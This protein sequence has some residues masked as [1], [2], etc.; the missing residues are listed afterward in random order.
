MKKSLLL[1]LAFVGIITFS[2]CSKEV[3][4]QVNDPIDASPITASE[5]M[6]EKTEIE[7]EVKNLDSYESSDELMAEIDEA[8]AELDSL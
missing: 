5:S 3:D 4:T 7:V 6:I 1:S 8:L 2:G